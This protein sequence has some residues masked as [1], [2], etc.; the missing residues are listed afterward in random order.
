M[1]SRDRGEE[2]NDE[3][4]RGEQDGTNHEYNPPH[5]ILDMVFP[6][7]EKIEENEAYDQG[8]ENGRKQSGW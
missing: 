8:N 3:H 2:L 7:E 5:G 6:T 1:G 4:N